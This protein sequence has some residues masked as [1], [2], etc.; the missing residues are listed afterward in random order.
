MYT[1][2]NSNCS[3][4][5]SADDNISTIS[6]AIVWSEIERNAVCRYDYLEFYDG[7]EKVM[8]T[9]YTLNVIVCN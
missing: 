3:W 8:Y 6:I 9:S 2:S 5:I 4:L 7:K 1:S